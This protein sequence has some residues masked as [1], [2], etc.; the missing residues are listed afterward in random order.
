M[1]IGK[2][3]LFIFVV[4]I[5]CF[6]NAASQ[7]TLSPTELEKFL[8]RA[9]VQSQN[10]SRVFKNL[11]AEE[12]KTKTFYRADGNIDEKRVVKSFFIIYQSPI[13]TSEFRFVLEFN[14]KTVARDEK[15]VE[16]FF[17]KLAKAKNYREEHE[18]LKKESLRYDGAGDFWGM[19][20]FQMR[21]L[22]SLLRSDFKF[23]LLGKEK[24]EGRDAWSIEYEQTK[25]SPYILSNP[26]KS[27]T[28]G[29][30]WYW[31]Y[32]TW[33]SDAFRP[34]NALLKGKLVFDTETAQM[35]RN[36]YKVYIQPKNLSRSIVSQE[37]VY[38]YQT[39]E[40]GISVPKKIWLVCFRIKGSDE[41]SLDVR[42]YLE[43]NFDY[44][45]FNEFKT[46][47]KD[48]QTRN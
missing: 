20:M 22:I 29:K 5:L 10:Y 4:F 36:E 19:T 47:I 46:E 28:E 14:G 23:K 39:S 42:K 25:T 38:E 15:E 37:G 21:P 44:S 41:R 45:K 13:F 27:E 33:I 34:T 7:E 40:F 11:S 16:K 43:F 18:R 2:S 6:Q 9:E 48:Y 31:R 32:D 12:L 17:N 8:D 24:I 35:M 3:G 26:L 1:N 30:T